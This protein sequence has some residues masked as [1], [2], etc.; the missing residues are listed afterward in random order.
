MVDGQQVCKSTGTTNK[1]LAQKRQDAWRTGIAQGQYSLLK[2]APL[3]EVWIE[4][5][6][7]SVDH[8]NTRRRYKSS[9]ENLVAFFGESRLDH[10]SAS[11]IED[12]KRA[13]GRSRSSVRTR[14]SSVPD[15]A[16]VK[17]R[18]LDGASRSL[19]RGSSKK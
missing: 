4:K 8:A 7:E 18:A 1:R 17:R 6:L 16:W 10:I 11:R 2:K 9:G 14:D 3:L 19:V 5:Y 12:F 15:M 13:R